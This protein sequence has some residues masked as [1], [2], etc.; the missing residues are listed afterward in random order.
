MTKFTIRYRRHEGQ[1]TLDIDTFELNIPPGAFFA[2]ALLVLME[3]WIALEE[4]DGFEVAIGSL[5]IHPDH[6]YDHTIE[7]SD[8]LSLAF[9]TAKRVLAHDLETLKDSRHEVGE[10]QILSRY[11]PSDVLSILQRVCE[12]NLLRPTLIELLERRNRT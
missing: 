8:F 10:L 6:G 1:D 9:E 7:Y 12:P 4:Q 3:R 11:I 2:E 5:P